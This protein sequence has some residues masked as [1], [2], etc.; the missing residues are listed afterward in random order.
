MNRLWGRLWQVLSIDLPW[1]VS[2]W[3]WANILGPLL[4]GLRQITSRTIFRVAVFLVVAWAAAASLPPDLAVMFA[5]DTT[6]YFEIASAFYLA[7]ARGHMLRA[8][9]HASQ[10]LRRGGQSFIRAMS[11][12]RRAPRLPRLFDGEDSGEEPDGAFGFA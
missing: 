8:V 1:A 11:R 3:L 2:N 5:G 6:L 7:I 10:A 4:A 12:A 9:I